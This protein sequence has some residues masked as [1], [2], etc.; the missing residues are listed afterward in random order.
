MVNREWPARQIALN[1]VASF[2]DKKCTLG[3]GLNP[4]REDRNLE[5]MTQPNNRADNR[6]RVAVMLQVGNKAAI[7]DY[8]KIGAMSL[9]DKD[10]LPGGTSVGNPQRTHRDHFKAHAILNRM[11]AER[12]RKKERE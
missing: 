6:H 11:V 7:G 12:D 4:L 5:A 9:V 8:A 1:F 2:L 3:F 10:V